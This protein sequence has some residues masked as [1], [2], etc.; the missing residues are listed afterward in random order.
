MKKNNFTLIEAIVA[1]SIIIIIT[2]F[3]TAI[4][5]GCYFGY[6]AF[7]SVEEH[8][9]KGTIETVYEGKGK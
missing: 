8:G 3:F 9:I 4:S 6:K 7:C 1:F 5:V 2:G